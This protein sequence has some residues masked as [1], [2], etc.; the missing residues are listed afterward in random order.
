MILPAFS[1]YGIELEYMIVDRDSLNVMA[2]SDEVLKSIA[3]EYTNEVEQGPIAYSNEVVLHVMELKTN[4]PV[5]TVHGRTDEFLQGI[6]HI[7]GLLADRNG[8]LMPTA[9]HPWMNPHTETRLWPH[10]ASEIYDTYNR[11]FNCSGHGWSNLQSMHINLPFED[12]EEFAKLHTA[13]RT[14]LPIMPAL[15]ASSPLMDAELTGLMDTRLETY[16]KNADIIPSI[17]GL[18][19][20]EPVRNEQEYVNTI[21]QPMYR[22]IAPYDPDKILQDEWLNSRGA[23]ARFDRN[24]IEIRVLDTQETARADLAIAAIIIEVLRKLYDGAWANLTQQ[25]QIDTHK[26]ADIFSDAVRYGDETIIRDREFLSLFNFPD[27][28]GETR[29]L[30]MY[31]YESVRD[32]MQTQDPELCSTLEFIIANGSLARRISRPMSRGVRRGMLHETY[33]VLTECLETDRLFEG[34]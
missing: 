19:I 9:M 25:L 7:N 3:G 28:R 32:S 2:C 12:D 10:D 33:R 15:A 34:I 20:P 16:R 18:V 30:W 14:L 21:L 13:I 24:T 5:T 31:L 6:R 17:T 27:R 26:L 22:D 4:G 29:E 11:I 1:A 23:I 8:I